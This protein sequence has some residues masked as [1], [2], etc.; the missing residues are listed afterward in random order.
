MIKISAHTNITNPEKMGYPY[1]ESIKSFADFCDEV[2]VVDGG[3]VDGSLEKIKKIPRVRI[4]KGHR[5]PEYFDWLTM[6]RNLQI[7]FDECKNKWAFKF[8]VDYIFDSNELQKITPLLSTNLPAIEIRKANFVLSNTYFIKDTYP[9]L[10]NK[11]HIGI[12]YGIA[13]GG[14]SKMPGSTFMKPIIKETKVDKELYCGKAV[15]RKNLKVA[16][17]D[18]KVYCYD[19]TFM[20]KAQIIEQRFRF[21]KSLRE[22]KEDRSLTREQCY[23]R[24][25][26]MMSAR[27]KKC[28]CVMMNPSCH[29][30]HIRKKI[31][32]LRPDQFG[33]NMF[34]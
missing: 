29:P 30:L 4:V 3:S 10:V 11:D 33:Y 17:S 22:Y 16:M 31:I 9:L 27:L 19:F 20:T 24:F 18:A 12:G 8:D 6:P 14:G 15:W 23:S 25:K 2:I 7:G 1:L 26:K 21:E 32:N 5:W 34:I 13:T 28:K